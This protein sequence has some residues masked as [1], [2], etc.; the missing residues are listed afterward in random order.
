M[1]W[2]LYATVMSSLTVVPTVYGLLKYEHLDAGFRALLRYF[3]FAVA[4][5][6]TATILSVMIRNNLGLLN[7]VLPFQ[8]SMI[9][10]AFIQWQQDPWVKLVMKISIY[11][12]IAVWMVENTLRELSFNN[13]TQVSKPLMYFMVVVTA[14]YMIYKDNERLD[15]PLLRHPRFWIS[16]GFLT[17]FAAMFMLHLVAYKFSQVAPDKYSFAYYLISPPAN[18]L[19]TILFFEGFICQSQTSQQPKLQI[20][21]G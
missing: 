16:A 17:Y 18:F 13:F 21:S 9:M 19:S 7:L 6:A 11:I 8:L 3:I 14:G 2:F 4:Y 12:F 15:I 5:T 1:S 10:Y 20:S